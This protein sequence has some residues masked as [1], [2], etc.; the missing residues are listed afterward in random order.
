M[1]AVALKF[2][3]NIIIYKWVQ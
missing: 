3:I 2:E 1:S